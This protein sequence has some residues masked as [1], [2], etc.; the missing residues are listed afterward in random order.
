MTLYNSSAY[1]LKTSGKTVKLAI[2]DNSAYT[3]GTEVTDVITISDPEELSLIDKGAF[4]TNLSFDIKSYLG[5]NE[6][7]SPVEIPD[8]GVTLYAKAWVVDGSDEEV[9][10]FVGDNNFKTIVCP[11]MV[12]RNGGNA[13]KVEVQ[14]ANSENQT[15]A[16][17]TLQNLSMA[18]VTNGN[19]AVNLLDAGGNIIKTQYLSNTAEGLVNFD[20]EA[21]I[22]K[23]F[24]FDTLGA[25]V[26]AYYFTATAGAMNADLQVLAVSG[27][28]LNFDKD[29]TTY[30][31][32]SANSLQST[33]L[34]AISANPNAKVLLKDAS[35]MVLTEET[36]AV[37][38]TLPL[39]T[40]SNSFKVTV[41]PDSAGAQPKTYALTVVNAAPASGSVTLAA[42]SPTTR[43]WWNSN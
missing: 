22:N 12:K 15:T 41:E 18:S 34:T 20:S 42:S 31:N 43:G 13:I 26:E 19:V 21:I 1:K 7:G 35:N 2:Y 10:E 29:T 40:G 36:G 11:N 14:Q 39:S 32:L 8:N 9:D 27:M 38:Y 28:G 25:D 17:L 37:A 5:E 4:V 16:I 3:V 33:N 24:V 6:D 30:G 23:T